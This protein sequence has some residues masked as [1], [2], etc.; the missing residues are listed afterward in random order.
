MST[1]TPDNYY[2]TL[3]VPL[4]VTDEELK[5]AYRQ[6]ARRYHPDIAGPGSALQMKRINRAY[7][8]LSDPE[9]RS[10]YDTVL[11]GSL[12]LRQSGMGRAHPQPQRYP[13]DIDPEFRS[14]RIFATRGPL[15]P[16]PV[17]SSNLGVVLALNTVETSQGATIA[18]GSLD[19]KGLIWRVGNT[20]YRTSFEVDPRL[21]IDSL[22]AVRFSSDGSLLAGWSGTSLHTW[23]SHDGRLLWSL[24]LT[25]RAVSAYYSIDVLP[26]EDQGLRGFKLALPILADDPLA[27]RSLGVRGTDIVEHQAGTPEDHFSG[28]AFICR[29]DSSEKRQFWAIRLRML[30]Q[31]GNSLL[32]FSCAT[33]QDEQSQSQ[34]QMAI[35]R[36]WDL[37][38]RTRFGGKP[39]PQVLTSVLVGLCQDCEPPYTVTPDAQQLAL[40]YG[41]Q[42]LRIYSMRDGTYNEMESGAMGASGRLAISPDGSW[43]AIAR[44]DSEINEGVIDL[45]SV[46]QGQLVQKLYHPWQIS[47]LRFHNQ[48]LIVALT[49]GTLQ[50]WRA[51]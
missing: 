2:A 5:Q 36:I 49:D 7:A 16:G 30:S 48:D 13:A 10:S 11:G 22:R 20:A 38:P 32:T 42:K 51:A 34:Q 12:D 18:A 17:L 37:T 19:G 25:N 33:I 15:R 46:H 8:V 31:I 35:A 4:N 23:D 26:S 24:N 21:P 29:E 40:L 28:P 47:A 9:K 44:E 50:I 1:D 43:V 39:R 45:W 41:K 6:L 27:P 3:G 14:M